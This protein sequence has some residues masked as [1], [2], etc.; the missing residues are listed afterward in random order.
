MTETCLTSK[1][2]LLWHLLLLCVA[3]K[4]SARELAL[5][6]FSSNISITTKVKA[7]GNND[8]ITLQTVQE[9]SSQLV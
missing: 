5:V 7:F 6:Q 8:F 4:Q 3:Y 1:P 2:N 9:F